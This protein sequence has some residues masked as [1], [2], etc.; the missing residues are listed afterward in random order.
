VPQINNS[1]G[2]FDSRNTVY[3]IENVDNCT[4]TSSSY[5]ST[6]Y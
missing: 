2:A 1:L 4:H 3:W 6:G 5:S